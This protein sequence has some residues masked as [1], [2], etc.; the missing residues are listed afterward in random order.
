MI[1]EV[2]AEASHSAIEATFLADVVAGLSQAPKT[3]PCKYFYDAH[4]SQLFERICGLNEYYLTRTELAIMQAH[5]ADM[6]R[7]LGPGRLLVEYGSGSSLKTRILLDRLE[8]PAG[9]VPV[10]VS[11]EHLLAACRSI[12]VDYPHVPIHPVCA[13][14]TR[15]FAL[16]ASISR[17]MRVVY[18]PGSTVGNFLPPAAKVLLR[19]MAHVA[20]TG[21][22]LVG[23]DL[24]KDPAVIEAAYNDALGLTSL[25]NLNMLVRINR[26]LGGTFDLDRFLHRAVYDRARGCIEMHLVSTEDQVVE[27]GGRPFCFAEREHILTEYSFKYTLEGFAELAAAAGFRVAKVWTDD[28]R[29]FAVVHLRA[30]GRA[31]D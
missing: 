8:S 16:P 3:L 18:C 31:G 14:F 6:A 10:D 25:F 29:W 21:G 19:A 2:H 5:A 28:R 22:A 27:V 17:R 24:Q 26:E 4:G 15:A 13:D 9:Y 7:H 11:R 20:G 1:S 12:A 23:I 30:Y